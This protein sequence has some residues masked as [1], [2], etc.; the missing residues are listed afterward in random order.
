MILTVFIVLVVLAVIAAGLGLTLDEPYFT[1]VGL[2]FLF[3]LSVLLMAGSLEV[4]SGENITTTYSYVNDTLDETQ[5]VMTYTYTN[6]ISASSWWYGFLLA[7]ASG[8]GAFAL[9]WNLKAA[10]QEKKEGEK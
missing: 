8:F 5:E 7:L 2:F 6:F 1:L 9:F 10:Y 4:P 3:N